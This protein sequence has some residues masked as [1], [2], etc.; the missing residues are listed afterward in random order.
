LNNGEFKGIF[1]EEEFN[2]ILLK[3]VEELKTPD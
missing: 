1:E 3:L 2:P